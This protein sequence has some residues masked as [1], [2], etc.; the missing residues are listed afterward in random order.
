MTFANPLQRMHVGAPPLQHDLVAVDHDA[1]FGIGQILAH[2]IPVDSV[3]G[4][5]V[6]REAAARSLTLA[7]EH[8]A[9][10]LAEELDVAER[11][12]ALAVR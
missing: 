9:V 10:D 4:H 3:G 7:G 2:E 8:I 5:P 11:L 6:E 1:A 12:P